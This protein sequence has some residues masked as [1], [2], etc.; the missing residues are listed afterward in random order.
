MTGPN[1]TKLFISYAHADGAA[2]AQHLQRDL[3]AGGLEPWLDTQRLYGGAIW[4]KE[5][6]EALDS[7]EVVLVHV[8][9][10]QKAVDLITCLQTRANVADRVY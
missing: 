4:T 8:V 10:F 3:A 6:E 9:S 2:L 1:S 7:A 5:I